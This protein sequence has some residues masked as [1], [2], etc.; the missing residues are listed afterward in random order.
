MLIKIRRP[1]APSSRAGA[2]RGRSF[3]VRLA[4]EFDVAPPFDA[5]EIW[6]A[7]QAE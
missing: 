5:V 4:A 7:A 6:K 3:A 1:N 2:A